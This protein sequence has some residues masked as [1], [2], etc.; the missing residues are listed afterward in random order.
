MRLT[1]DI[2]VGTRVS[3]APGELQKYQSQE[4]GGEEEEE[5]QCHHHHRIVL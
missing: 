4:Q 1:V 3:K 2:V 5:N